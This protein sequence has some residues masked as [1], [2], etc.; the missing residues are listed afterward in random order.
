[1]RIAKP[2]QAQRCSVMLTTSNTSFG[3]Q[4]RMARAGLNWTQRD[5]AFHARVSARTVK[6]VEADRRKPRDETQAKISEALASAGA[7]LDGDC[8][9]RIRG[10]AR[11]TPSA[12]V[13]TSSECRL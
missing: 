11:S 13:E 2:E 7:D 6:Y 3:V 12:V 10:D 9:V 8:S 5:L 4:V 1:M